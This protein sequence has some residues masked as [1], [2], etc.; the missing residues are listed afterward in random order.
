MFLM[1]MLQTGEI[2]TV[3]YRSPSGLYIT[4]C[5]LRFDN[6][7]IKNTLSGDN[8]FPGICK[9]CKQDC[10]QL[11]SAYRDYSLREFYRGNR[12]KL[13]QCA[14][15]NRLG[16]IGPLVVA[17]DMNERYWSKLIKYRSSIRRRK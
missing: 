16:L 8:I 15:L 5:E 17:E 11:E 7:T 4:H 14:D 13:N 2:H 10:E 6:K 12:T 3:S 9:N 1:V